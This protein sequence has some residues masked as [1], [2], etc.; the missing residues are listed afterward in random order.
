MLV[1]SAIFMSTHSPIFGQ[2]FVDIWGGAGYSSLYHGIEN[3]KFPGGFGY[4][5]GVGYE[6]K[7][8]NFFVLT[9]AEFMHYNSTTRLDAYTENKD[10]LYP[11]IPDHYIDF[12]YAITKHKEKHSFGYL[13]IPL[14]FGYRFDRYYAIVGAKVGLNLFGNYKSTGNIQTEGVDPMFI[15][16]LVNI[17]SHYIGTKEYSDNGKL[18]MGLNITP[19]VEFGVYLDEWLGGNFTQLRNRQRTN[20]SYR[21]GVFVDYGMVNIVNSKP[22]GQFLSDPIRNPL[23]V[24]VNDLSNSTLAKDKRFGSLMAGVKLAVLFDL[25]K[26]KKP[27]PKPQ[28]K[29]VRKL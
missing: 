16:T 13:N 7:L 29:P 24:S 1:L 2:S 25:T 6:Y 14:Q 5:L 10:F 12:H 15:D 18:S 26:Q 22:E 11:Y 4:N 21:A 23:D 3:T 8:N 17:P 9:G 19:G 27:K 20:I 28:A